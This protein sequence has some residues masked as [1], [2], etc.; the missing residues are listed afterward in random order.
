MRMLLEMGDEVLAATAKHVLTYFKSAEM[1]SVDFEGSLKSW[2]MFPKDIPGELVVLDA[3]STQTMR[4]R[5]RAFPV[6]ETGCCSRSG[7]DR[8]RSE[9]SAVFPY[10]S[11]RKG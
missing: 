1:D 9:P 10:D 2:T 4:N 11:P 3:L 8:R 6:K 5:W 7:S